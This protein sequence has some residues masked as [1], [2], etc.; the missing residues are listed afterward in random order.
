MPANSRTTLLLVLL[1][2]GGDVCA[3]Y[4][5]DCVPLLGSRWGSMAVATA[6][7]LIS[8]IPLHK[9]FTLITLTSFN[10]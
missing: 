1:I 8:I 5:A 2:S 10:Y 6:S 9:T 4:T 7:F 3:L